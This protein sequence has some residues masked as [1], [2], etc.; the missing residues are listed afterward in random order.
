MRIGFGGMAATPQRA[1]NVEAA[2]RAGDFEAAARAVAE[3]FQPIDDWRGTAAYRLH[4]A[5]ILLRRLK[6][7]IDNPE[8]PVEVEAL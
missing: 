7:R 5:A 2:L 6:L 3:D 4:V 1:P 8:Q